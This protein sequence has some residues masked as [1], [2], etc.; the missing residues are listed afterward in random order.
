M[1]RR[2][3]AVNA[4][5]RDTRIND[6]AYAA[7]VNDYHNSVIA[8]GPGSGTLGGDEVAPPMPQ[9]NAVHRAVTYLADK[10]G[11]DAAQDQ[12]YM[13]M[14]AST[15]S[16][17][18]RMSS[19]LGNLH[20]TSMQHNQMNYFVDTGIDG[21]TR[22]KIPAPAG[23][24]RTYAT[25]DAD[26]QR[27]WNEGMQAESEIQARF[28]KAQAFV[29]RRPNA[30]P[31]ISD[32]RSMYFGKSTPDLYVFADRMRSDPELSAL[33]DQYR[34]VLKGIHEDLGANP[35]Y[36]FYTPS[37]ARDIT[38]TR[39]NAV[40]RF[41]MEGEL[42]HPLEQ[43]KGTNLYTGQA[44]GG[45]APIPAL[46]GYVEQLYP[47]FKRNLNA[48]KV[49]DHMT[50][51]MTQPGAPQLMTKITNPQ[52]P[53]TAYYPN[54]IGRTSGDP[55][56][57]IVV[58]RTP[59]GP[60]HWRIDNPDIRNIISGDSLAAQRVYLD[61]VDV[62]RRV[63]QKGTTGVASLATGRAMPLRN[64]LFTLPAMAVTAR[65]GR[66]GGLLSRMTE[67]NLPTGVSK[68]VTPLARGL[69]MPLNYAAAPF[70]AAR[71]MADVMTRRFAELIHPN[72]NNFI[73]RNYRAMSGDA[74]VDA[75]HQAATNR[76]EQ[77]FTNWKDMMGISG[78]S[79]PMRVEAPGLA[80]GTK[81]GQLGGRERRAGIR[82]ETARI[83]PHAFVDGSWSGAARA[84]WINLQNT[85]GNV[86]NSLGEVGHDMWGRL[87]W[88]NPNLDRDTLAYEMRNLVGNPSR[89]GSSA[90]LGKVSSALPYTNVSMQG[91]GR[92]LQAQGERPWAT[93]VTIATG[94]GTA[95][96][97]SIF[98]H[99]RSAAHMDFMQNQLSLQQREA[100]IALAT[101]DDPTAPTMIPLP[102]EFR[103]AYAF[104]LDLMSKV[105]NILGARHDPDVF[106]SVYDGISHFLGSNITSS[107]LA[108]I[109]HGAVDIADFVNLPQFMGRV[110]WNAVL[111]GKD[112]GDA[113]HGVLGGTSKGP[114]PGQGY[115]AP[116][117]SHNG[118]LFES[119]LSNTFGA[120]GHS[121]A[122]AMNSP[123]RY[124]SQGH[125]WLDSLGL[126]G[127]DW[128]Q[129]ARQSNLSMNNMLWE[130]QLRL[131]V[132]PPIAEALTPSVY[133]LQHLPKQVQPGMEGYVGKQPNMLPAPMTA[134]KSVSSDMLIRQMLLTAHQ[135]Q[136]MI[137]QAM[138]PIDALRAQ[139]LAVD[140]VGMDPA[141]RT[142]WMN[143]R[144][145]ELA[146]KW[147]LVQ[148]YVAD[149]DN[150][151]S[152]MAGKGI[153]IQ[154][155]KWNQDSSQ[156]R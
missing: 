4:A 26:R 74:A 97:A 138:A 55:R 33:A 144:T 124:H 150:A 145:R 134:D 96:L 24:A 18:E 61:S 129:G 155:I 5:A 27:I 112:I 58:I 29:A 141:K 34:A 108:A 121:L 7:Q 103:P 132:N 35:I 148:G 119:L 100:N 82:L 99:M 56:D 15:A 46:A 120:V 133:A 72:A 25:L 65:T 52:R 93:P 105:V 75:M 53:H 135:Y 76:W 102:Q 59:D 68:Y 14:T 110:D 125:S 48:Q 60:E 23:P 83:V 51:F 11:N 63:Y 153:R 136:S 9:G 89:A 127:R 98:T 69:D 154:D 78:Q 80:M 40:P 38:A 130:T 85:M 12:N 140:K 43:T 81:A 126:T 95:A 128:L 122:E 106:Q 79:S 64:T 87:N 36:G 114:P 86:F 3:A 146:D 152:N 32:I 16:A 123:F 39:G 10:L 90:I 70:F 147:K 107:N 37:E 62:A 22:V 21:E 47:L 131:S 115:D 45:V 66:Y 49:R 13:N 88:D 142:D 77:S 111:Q 118:Q 104:M 101:S 149:L 30:T 44:S 151:M 1:Y 6:P 2:G 8:R 113:I 57:P 137:R 117:D 17:G 31:D 91:I 73:N 143:A 84:K 54:R 92:V 71:N 19:Q 116:L 20:D 94:L 67:R 156:F 139:M 41:T 42:V 28:N 50:D 109:R